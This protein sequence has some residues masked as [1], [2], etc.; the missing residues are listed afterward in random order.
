[1]VYIMTEEK[2]VESTGLYYLR[3]RFIDDSLSVS[4][5]T[6]MTTTKQSGTNGLSNIAFSHHR[7]A[8]VVVKSEIG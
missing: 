2:I 1:M 4:D 5:K 8:C 6:S 7:R 3:N